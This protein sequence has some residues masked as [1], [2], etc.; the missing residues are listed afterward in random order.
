MRCKIDNIVLKSIVVL[1]KTVKTSG[2][3]QVLNVTYNSQ[4]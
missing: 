4:L 1:N 3:I 2:L